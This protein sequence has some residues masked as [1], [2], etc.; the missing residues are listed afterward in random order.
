MGYKIAKVYYIIEVD[1]LAVISSII[2]VYNFI[3]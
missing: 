2:D 3:L 1:S